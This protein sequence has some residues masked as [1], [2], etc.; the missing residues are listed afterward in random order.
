MTEREF[1]A[2]VAAPGEARL[3][4]AEILP[5]LLAGQVG[6]LLDDV[7]LVVS[8]LVTNAVRAG[9][10]TI[11]LDIAPTPDGRLA[12]RVTDVAGGWPRPRAATAEDPGGR[13]LALVSAVASAWGARREERGKTVWAELTVPA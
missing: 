2:T 8:E 12:I 1:M 5:E 13:G 3:F 10:P 11:R 6:G 7:Q 4:A 9:S